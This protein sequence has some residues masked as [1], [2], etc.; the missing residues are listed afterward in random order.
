MLAS[1]GFEGSLDWPSAAWSDSCVWLE[2][3]ERVRVRFLLG[4]CQ[5]NASRCVIY[6]GVKECL[7]ART[8][9]AL[10]LVGFLGLDSR[11]LRIGFRRGVGLH[12]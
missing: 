11:V 5:L 9:C 12:P 10:A 8:S 3:V 4:V 1:E 2:S 7:I 6:V